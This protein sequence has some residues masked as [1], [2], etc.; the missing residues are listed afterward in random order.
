[1]QRIKTIVG[2][3]LLPLLIL[4]VGGADEG[5]F[6]Q[7]T[8]P[9]ILRFPEDH[10]PHPGFRTE[11]WYYTGNLKS[12]TGRLFGFQLT[13]FRSRLKPPRDRKKWPK[14][15]SAWRTDQLF[16]AHAAVT[17]VTGRR[18]LQAE[19]MARPVLDLAGAAKEAEAWKIHLNNWQAVISSDRHRLAAVTD[20]FSL[21]L[22]LTPE[23]PPVLH[24]EGGYSRKGNAPEQASCYY[25]FTRLSARGA[26]F[27]D[28]VDIPVSGSAWM[29]HEFSTAPLEKSISGWDWFSL[30]LSDQSEVM[31][32][33]LRKKDGTLHPATSGTFVP[34]K[35][36]AQ[37]L[38][39]DQLRV[40]PLSFWTSPESGGRYPV[41]WKLLV[42][43]LQLELSIAAT[44]VNQE[45]RTPRS[46]NVVY[47][48]GSVRVDGR[49]ENTALKGVG[50]VELTGYA[51]TFEA[52]M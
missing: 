6:M 34:T 5:D 45:M 44:P 1:M 19:A 13:F 46:T 35:G 15:A 41:K 31:L 4:P 36:P 32:Y 7:V 8:G 49:K 28:G 9:C 42:K 52:P 11:W 10:G 43:G 26:I 22:E 48:E 51:A 21:S 14:P 25:S 24:G 20:N 27:L 50:Y 3:M 23:K 39:Q 33:L 30:Q 37:H 29:D 16:L 2:I 40:T 12:E 38:S 18:H 47:W 17:D